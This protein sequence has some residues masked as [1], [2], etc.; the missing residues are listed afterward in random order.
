VQTVEIIDKLATFGR[1][2]QTIDPAIHM[3]RTPFKE[4]VLHDTIKQ[5]NQR[6]RL[7]SKDVG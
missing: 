7:Q 4:F 2:I 1:K 3:I 6:D 5:S